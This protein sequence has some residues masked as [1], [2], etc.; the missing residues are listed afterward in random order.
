MSRNSLNPVALVSIAEHQLLT[1]VILATWEAEIGRVAVQDQPGQI[2]GELLIS[3]ITTA[4]KMDGKCGSS[5]RA[6]G[7][8]VGSPEFKP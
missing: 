7:L 1:P 3:K 5:G 6:P 8:Q 2:V 4:N